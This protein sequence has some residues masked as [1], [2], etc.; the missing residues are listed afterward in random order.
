MTDEKEA[1]VG[2]GRPP[3]H[4]QFKPGQ[5]GNPTGWARESR[6]A[7]HGTEIGNGDA[8]AAVTPQMGS[9]EVKLRA[10]VHRA[11]R[12][13]DLAAL[14]EVLRICEKYKVIKPPAIRGS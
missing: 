3:R 1:R 12:D 14:K 2:Y 6:K 9:F 4:T 5:S 8:D 7:R 10:L 11:L 13:N